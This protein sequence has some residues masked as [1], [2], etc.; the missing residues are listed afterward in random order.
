MAIVNI[1]GVEGGE[2][3]NSQI[4]RDEFDKISSYELDRVY[5][6]IDKVLKSANMT[7]NDI[8]WVEILGGS[9]RIPSVQ[10][11]LRKELGDKLGIHMNGDDSM[12]FGAAFIAANYSS[13]FKL[14]QRLE[15]YHGNTFEILIKLKHIEHE[16]T[17]Q[18]ICADDFDGLAEHCNRKLNK[19]APLFKIR[20]G[21]DISKTVSMKH[22]GNFDIFVY[23]RFPGEEEN[24]L[25]TYKIRG[26][27]ES[28]AALRA[29]NITSKP[30]VNLKFKLNKRGSVGL[31]VKLILSILIG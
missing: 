6:P 22:D 18:E 1:L 7:L 25:M 20:H 23:E 19:A 13:N 3:L 17:T 31:T 10:E 8:A 12:A 14:A 27:Q 9:V 24:L 30:K 5:T 26:I 2:N 28:L 29:D 16:N 15:L 11:V 21:L 4:S